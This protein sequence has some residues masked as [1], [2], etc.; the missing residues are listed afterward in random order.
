MFVV[1]LTCR[2]I[3]DEAINSALI[4]F[5]RARCSRASGGRSPGR[6]RLQ[7]SLCS[8]GELSEPCA[9]QR[10]EDVGRCLGRPGLFGGDSHDGGDDFVGK[11][12]E[13]SVEVGVWPDDAQ[14]KGGQRR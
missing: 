7:A 12:V 3:G 10:V 11:V 2:M 9:A 13:D 1:L 4:E 5:A 8:I 6:K 14:P